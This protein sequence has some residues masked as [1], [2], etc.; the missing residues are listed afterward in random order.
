[1]TK[2]VDVENESAVQEGSD[3]LPWYLLGKANSYLDPRAA[4]DCYQVAL[5]C[6]SNCSI[7]WLAVGKLY[8]EL[9]QLKDALEAYSQALKLQL[10]D[11]SNGTAT[12]WDGLSCVYERCEDQL[13][14]ASDACNRAAACFKA[15]GDIKSCQF[16]RIEP[17]LWKKLQ[18][19][20]TNVEFKGSTRCA[21]F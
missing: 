15:M 21:N 5:R 2:V 13:M 6:A 20:G 4:Y 11:G 10:G 7:I 3:F 8:L 19:G 18:K 12:A 16:S 14:D 1:M 17:L 9:K